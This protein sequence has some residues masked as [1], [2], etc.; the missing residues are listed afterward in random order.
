M[1]TLHVLHAD[2]ASPATCAAARRALDAEP[3]ADGPGPRLVLIG[4]PGALRAAG[5]D[6]LV[7]PAG[8][9]PDAAAVRTT[10]VS[11]RAGP[12]ASAV[13]R[14]PPGGVVRAW[15][16]AAA[17]AVRRAAGRD[18]DELVLP[19]LPLGALRR[20]ERRALAVARSIEAADEYLRERLRAMLP[21]PAH[22]RLFA[23]DLA[24]PTDPDAPPR[25]AVR[26]SWGVGPDAF[27]IAA[28]SHPAGSAPAR[29][30]S[31][32]AGVLRVSGRPAA[33]VVPADARSLH[34][35][36][37]FADDHHSAWPV[38]AEQRPIRNW[39][40]GV[41]LALWCAPPELPAPGSRA[42]EPPPRPDPLRLALERGVAILAED[43]PAVRAVLPPDAAPPAV[44][45]IPPGS[46]LHL[47]RAV[48]RLTDEALQP[49]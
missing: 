30:A 20:S 44:T 28:V 37:R 35:A 9:A 6:L 36:R 10:R 21:G 3:A 11:F 46:H 34:A 33:A 45:L 32:A 7:R 43:H 5:G 42:I 14:L 41:D 15:S 47:N 24:E 31:Y 49:N 18:A 26:R 22:A 2:D 13:R 29:T 38:V 27:V 17:V 39:L 8:A 19:T 1:P 4:S 23:G 12:L 16:L 25:D 40:Q 48:A